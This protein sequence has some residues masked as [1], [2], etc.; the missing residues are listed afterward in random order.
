M[1][2]TKI[3]TQYYLLLIIYNFPTINNFLHLYYTAKTDVGSQY[4]KTD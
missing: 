2:V 4:R 1:L 3:V